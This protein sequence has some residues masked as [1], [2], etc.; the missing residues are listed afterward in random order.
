MAAAGYG[1]TTA[2]RETLPGAVWCADPDPGRLA[3]GTLAALAAER[4]QWIVVDD[5]PPLP[6]A[7]G[8]A[9]LAAAFALPE[10]T[11]V[12][13]STRRPFDAGAGLWRGRGAL[14]EVRPAELALDVD[15]IADVLAAYGLVGQ[16]SDALPA[17][18]RDATD[19][20]PALVHLAAET[21]RASGVPS[22]LR[23]L[24]EPGTPLASYVDEEILGPLPA[25]T[26]RLLRDVAAFAPVAPGLCAALGHPKAHAALAALAR[27]GLLTDPTAPPPRTD[28]H[29]PAYPGPHAAPPMTAP[30]PRPHAD[31]G[32]TGGWGDRRAVRAGPRVVPLVAAV[33]ARPDRRRAGTAAAWYE[34]H[35]PPL[36]A[37]RAHHDAGDPARTAAVLDAHGAAILGAGGAR[38]IVELTGD[39]PLSPR[40]TL[41][42]GD[43]LRTAG[44]IGRARRAYACAADAL[45]PDDPGVAWRTGLVHY[46]RHE[47][48]EALAAFGKARVDPPDVSTVDGALVL[49]WTAVARLP[50]GDTATAL[51][52]AFRAVAAAEATG[53]DRTQATAHTA[54]ALCLALTGDPAGADRH[55]AQALHIAERAG[56]RLLV[57]RI[58]V[59]RTFRLLRDARYPEALG[60]ARLAV[61][62]AASAGHANL[63]A[64]AR[65]NE[66]SA[67]SR[68]GRHDE[69]TRR[70]DG[71]MR[72]FH[73]LGSRRVAFP[74]VHIA[75][76]HARRGFPQ[77]ART[78]YQEAVR[79]ARD[80]G[81]DQALAL[82]LAGL[83]RTLAVEEPEAAAVHAE[84]AMRRAGR[85]ARVPALLGRGWVA[86][87]AGDRRA[88]T[89]DADLAA[90]LA[91]E[92]RER[93]GLAEALEL[94][95]AVTP[96]PAS[97]RAAL[98]EALAIWRDGGAPVDADRVLV[99]LGGLPGAGTDE[100]L[101]ALLAAR[102]LAAAHPP[103]A[104]PRAG[105]DA[106]APPAG[107]DGATAH[108]ARVATGRAAPPRTPLHAI[109]PFHVHRRPL[110]IRT[111][112]QFEVLLDGRPVPAS[113]W[114][115]RKARDL[116]RILVARRGRPIPRPE[117]A[118][119]LWPDDDP[120]RTGHRLSV[121]LSIVRTVLDPQ[122]RCDQ[123]VV[124]DAAGVALDV[125]RL[126]VDVEDFLADVR[127]A[128][129]LRERGADADAR[130]LLTAALRGYADD[131]FADEPYADW[132]R[133]LRE[134]GR[135]AYLRALR[136]LADLGRAAGDVEDALHH[137]GRILERDP[138]DEP[139]H[140]ATVATLTAG[141]RHGEARRAFARWAAAMREIGVRPPPEDVLVRSRPRT[142]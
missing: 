69:A 5:L 18:L 47:T 78:A 118:E 44:D 105:D 29:P 19:G 109:A 24:A 32:P 41:L 56:D 84:E 114:Q 4:P 89:A 74:L 37:A 112:G 71:V 9:L 100:R 119:L 110:S 28:R 97:A 107:P 25:R 117:L 139:A 77:Q 30:C 27:T 33:A 134:E 45:G 23:D 65:C 64:I 131:P 76:L 50:H 59:N 17:R 93:A 90:A 132:T 57:A 38:D 126:H 2:L 49:A 98:A 121:L 70:F 68:L 116:L 51:D 127:H 62:A 92:L 79:V 39:L 15:A 72:A 87:H 22:E 91:R 60:T 58:Q 86:A 14:H 123:Y 108:P 13:L 34:R 54:L 61:A 75:D 67:L 88:A 6:A 99:A 106:A 81:D 136:T 73:R 120:A 104:A 52:E 140:R 8:R 85:D 20:W 21:M 102:R 1:K 96:D 137:L 12:V 36:S 43:A 113:A 82:A 35:G 55:H 11:R 101:D 53:D 130:A 138:Y 129:R 10:H 95:A 115:S 31:P 80:S 16:E 124:A 40:L 103:A 133:P 83:A 122:K 26:L 66:A 7:A 63:H 111:L 125:G 141:G 135:A 46:L 142:R 94:R 128:A 48:H 3:A 42:R